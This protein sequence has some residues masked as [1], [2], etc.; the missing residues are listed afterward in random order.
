MKSTAATIGLCALLA[1][2]ILP[3]TPVMAD[4]L[5][6]PADHILLTVF[7]RHDQSKNLD[8]IQAELNKSGFWQAF[9]P[10]GVEVESWNVVM[11]IGQ[12]ITLRVPPEKLRAV[13]YT[14]ERTAWGPYR[15][16]FYATYDLR[17]VVR[18]LKARAGEP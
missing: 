12:V 17:A 9:P 14:L 1:A 16:E 18:D 2:A 4:D 15:T 10:E 7:L 6:S 8:Q 13:N 11:G 3:A 5:A